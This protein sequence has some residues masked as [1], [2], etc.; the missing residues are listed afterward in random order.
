MAEDT[1]AAPRW[2]LLEWFLIAQTALPAMLLLPG[3]QAFRLPLRVAPFALS[4]LATACL[5]RPTNRSVRV[6]PAAWWLVLAVID[7]GIMIIHPE[8]NG[9]VAGVAHVALY[10][11]VFAP[12]FWVPGLVGSAER[13]PRL[14][15]ILL[16][17]SGLNALV[18]VLQVYDPATW[19]PAE[20][21][22]I[23]VT[24]QFGLENVSYVGRDGVR[25]VRPPGL[26]DN[27]GAVCAPG[28]VAALLGFVF[29]LSPIRPWQRSLSAICALVG[30]AAIYLSHVR[31]AFVVLLG[32][33]AFY[34]MTLCMQ[35]R[36][37]TAVTFG[38]LVVAVGAGG[39]GVA[40]AL[41]GQSVIDRFS[42]LGEAPL[43][44]YAA[45]RGEFL[46]EDF[47]FL[48]HD[49]PLG[50]GLGRWGATFVYFGGATSRS[51][52][53]PGIEVQ[54]NAWIVDGGIVLVVLYVMALLWNG[55]RELNTVKRAQTPALKTWGA[56]IFALNAGTC[57][58]IF[59]FT[60]FTTQTGL[61]YWFLAGL[62]YGAAHAVRAAAPDDRPGAVRRSQPEMT[63]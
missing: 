22:T 26:F 18:G 2:G 46:V 27:P 44:V 32:M 5:F 28:A 57:L 37:A 24:S 36:F 47:T 40:A 20:F 9:V 17:S 34:V 13:L 49:H 10:V 51:P 39:L 14:L 35:R 43:Q 30:A 12:L 31:A 55:I 21:S 48:L 54:P 7:L 19:M 23:K 38:L 33:A 8:T 25:V 59:S 60:P 42:T 53:E 41:G 15:A 3:S 29:A 16:V 6:H 11:S 4:L 62:L 58:L 45:G 1:K 56:S 61:Q 63:A 52:L 50:A